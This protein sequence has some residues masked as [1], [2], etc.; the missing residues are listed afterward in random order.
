LLADSP[1]V[2][3][4]D[5]WSLR[6]CFFFGW[7][8]PLFLWLILLSVMVNFVTGTYLF[9]TPSRS[10]L[11]LG[12]AFN[13]SLLGYF[14]Y[15]GFLTGI[16]FDAIDSTFRLGDILLPLG[17]S[18]FTFQQIT[19]SDSLLAILFCFVLSGHVY[20]VRPKS[21]LLATSRH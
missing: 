3:Q 21:P 10:I 16:I 17:I 18:F 11:I 12:I 13:L 15:A 19:S 5:G 2:W 7:W 9:H 6:R 14:K 8:N 1:T 4:W 20:H